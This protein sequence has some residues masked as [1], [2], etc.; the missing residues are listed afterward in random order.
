MFHDHQISAEFLLCLGLRTDYMLM[1]GKW[2]K[3]LVHFKK[4]YANI[5]QDRQYYRV[6]WC[7]RVTGEGAFFLLDG[8]VLQLTCKVRLKEF[9]L[10]RIALW[11]ESGQYEVTGYYITKGEQC[12]G[13]R[14]GGQF[15]EKL[16][17][18]V[19]VG[20]YG[21]NVLYEILKELIKM[22]SK[23][24]TLGV[25]RKRKLSTKKH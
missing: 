7:W 23:D 17:W 8:E 20:E 2:L 6:C 10:Q 4:Y 3:G 24:P 12:C 22:F 5:E 9:M 16:K 13:H 14:E 1:E 25:M 21:Q 18:W 15:Q 11:P 19:G